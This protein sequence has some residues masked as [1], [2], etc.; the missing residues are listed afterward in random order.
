MA[1]TGRI[2]WYTPFAPK[3]NI[4]V[5]FIFRE[6]SLFSLG[7][8]DWADFG[9]GLKKVLAYLDDENVPGFNLALFSAPDGEDPFAQR[10]DRCEAFPPP[11]E[12]GGRQLFREDPHGKHVHAGARGRGAPSEGD[13]VK[14]ARQARS[15]SEAQRRR[16]PP[17]RGRRYRN[18]LHKG[19]PCEED[20]GGRPHPG[21][22]R[23]RSTTTTCSTT[24]AS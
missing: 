20:E 6:S 17:G 15:P 10:Q 19:L 23:H 3:G 12:R 24:A 2:F 7:D 11:G 18:D 8:E 16:H 13:M 14:E 9:E 22:V 4:D 5:G 21:R 1:G